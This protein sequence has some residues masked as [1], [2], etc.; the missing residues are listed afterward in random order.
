MR[1]ITVRILGLTLMA[2]ML[3]TAE[4]TQP[5]M[6]GSGISVKLVKGGLNGP[7]GFTF[8]P[9]G[10]IY[11]AERGTGRILTLNPSN[12]H[13]HLVFT[14][15]GVNGDGERGALGVALH[16][17]WPAVPYIYVYVTR[18]AHGVLRN[19]VLRIHVA[20]GHGTGYQ[21]LLQS[22][23][24]S[25]PYHNGGRILFGPGGRLFVFVGDGHHDA[26]AQDRTNNLQGKLLRINPDGSIPKGNPFKGSRIW[27]YGN[28]NSYG[29]AFDPVTGRIWETENGPNCNDEINL[30]V[31]GANFGWGPNENCGGTSPGDTNNSGPLPRHAPKVFFQ[32]PLGITGDAFCHHCGLPAQ[33]EGRLFFGCVNDGKLRVLGLNAARDAVSTGPSELLTVSGGIYSMETA[34]NGQIYLSNGGAIY[35]LT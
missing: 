4:A 17:K 22:P 19:Q 32:S 33:Y 12:G 16:P 2:A 14:I 13:E 20:N 25:D 23:A 30:M 3:T 11:Y 29:Y 15:S 10:L 34:P 5:A 31:R 1:R 7:A 18:M 27:T 28:R 8:G 35:K 26:N 24:A 6:A 21:V 9:G